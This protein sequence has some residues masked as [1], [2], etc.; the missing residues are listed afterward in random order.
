MALCATAFAI[1]LEGDNPATAR[2]PITERDAVT[3]RRSVIN[4]SLPSP[5][6]NS[7]GVEIDQLFNSGLIFFS[8]SSNEVSPLIFSPLTK[9]VGVESTFS[10]SLAYFWSAAILSSND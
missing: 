7:D 1:R 10:T 8:N 5:G 2:S 9:K 6:Q 3:V 4:G